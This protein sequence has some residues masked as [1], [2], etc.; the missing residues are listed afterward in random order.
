MENNMG[1]MDATQAEGFFND[2]KAELELSDFGFGITT[3][4]SICM[5]DKILI[6]ERDLNYPWF[7]KQLILHEIAHHLVPE[8]MTHGTRF[9]KKY[10]EL[11]NRFLAGERL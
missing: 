1:N 7:T 10:A 6:D 8:D 5:G 9:H 4:G 11:V 3:A 2:V